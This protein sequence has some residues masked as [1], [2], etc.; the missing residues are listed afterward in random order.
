[1]NKTNTIIL[2]T[3]CVNPNGMAFT[4][5]Q[6]SE[7]RKKQYLT[8]VNWYLENTIEKLVLVENSNCDLSNYFTKYILNK[9]LEII[10]FNGNDYDRSLGKGFGEARIINEALIHSRFI[11]NCSDWDCII[12]ISGRLIIQNIRNVINL[13]INRTVYGN[14]KIENG[15][16]W[17]NSEIIKAPKSFF[18]KYFIKNSHLLND[19]KNYCFENLMYDSLILWIRDGMKH[20]DFRFPLQIEGMSGTRGIQYKR[21]SK[22]KYIT[23]YIKY[24]FHKLGIYRNHIS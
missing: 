24:I 19:S 17:C 14:T 4:A 16:G 22:I 11:Q 7:E 15:K 1:M 2:L 13:P 21:K 9:R 23:S 12:K 6:D 5:L 20:L 10:T 18:L 3:A 8:A